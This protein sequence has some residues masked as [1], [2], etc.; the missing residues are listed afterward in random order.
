MAT[1]LETPGSHWGELR[2]R[3]NN[4]LGISNPLFITRRKAISH[5]RL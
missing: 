5:L 2:W 3:Q 4:A 1:G